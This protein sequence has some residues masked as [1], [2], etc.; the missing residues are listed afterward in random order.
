MARATF[1]S[2]GGPALG[3]ETKL[4]QAADLLRGHMDAAEYKHTVLGLIFL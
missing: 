4:W 2:E 3:F 1:N